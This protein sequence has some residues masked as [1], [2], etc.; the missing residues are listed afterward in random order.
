MESFSN[1]FWLILIAATM[2]MVLLA[3]FIV[4]F[5]IYYQKRMLQ[6]R[7]EQQNIEAAY[8]IKMLQATLDSQETERRRIAAELHDSIGGLLNVIRMNVLNMLKQGAHEKSINLNKEIIDE[9]ILSLRKIGKDL[10]P[11]SLEKLGL[12]SAVS[13]LCDQYGSS[14]KIEITFTE[15]G[16]TKPLTDKEG[17]ALFRVIQELLNNAI[18]HASTS[19]ISIHFEWTDDLEISMADYGKGFDYEDAK[20]Q[21]TG[22]GLFNIENRL[23]AIGAEYNF[24]NDSNLGM[25]SMIKVTL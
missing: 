7:V 17:I 20:Q 16:D 3:A 11:L 21:S 9:T 19:R 4:F 22:L 24:E 23:T 25:K 15:N 13:E 5:V 14:A 8:Q 1:E 6:N 18:K 10:M 12:S 2:G